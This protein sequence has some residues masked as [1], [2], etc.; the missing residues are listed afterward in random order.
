M[1]TTLL[2]THVDST[3]PTCMLMFP[4]DTLDF[5]A[6]LMVCPNCA[7]EFAPPSPAKTL[8]GDRVLIDRTAF[9]VRRPGRW[10]VVAFHRASGGQDL[11]V[12]RV[13][14]LPGEEIQIK[15]GDIYA[16][17]KIQRKT[18]RQQRAMRVL[19]HDEDY[20]N[21][22]GATPRWRP[23]DVGSNWTRQHGRLV[24]AENTGDDIGWLVYN[25]V[26]PGGVHAQEP[27]RVTDYN[28]YN[29]GRFQRN[30]SIHPMAD[31]AM[32]F[33]IEDIHGRGLLW[34]QATDG[35]DEFMVQIDPGLGKFLVLKNR[36]KNR[37]APVAAS[38]D[39]PGSLRGQTIEVS[40]FDRQFLMSIAGQTLVAAGIDMPGPPPVA[41]QPLA[42]GAEGLGVVV[43]R[44]RVYRDVYYTEPPFAAPGQPLAGR[45][46]S[47]CVLG[48]EEYFVLGDNSPVSED[49]RTW[50]ENRFV[51][52]KSLV[53][54]PFV[55][56]YPACEISLGGWQIQ[57]PDLTRIRYIR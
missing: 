44:L 28:F 46:A 22:P 32:S 45:G 2:G 1:A 27:A 54:K 23:Q 42:I 57:V 13:V 55:V 16:D 14:G 39:L 36:E 8:A 29:R 37:Q 5:N 31:V 10:E 30:D 12:K 11:V 6:T 20:D 40:L 38:G 3:C 47:S 33:R 18:L 35:R 56:I 21:Y 52:L 19:V 43:D 15:D 17:G 24:H 50:T 9:Q 26:S 48:A 25:H 7:T 4:C 41:D 34:L 49:S 53:G 51:S